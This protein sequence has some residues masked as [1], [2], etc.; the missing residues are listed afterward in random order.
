MKKIA[1]LASGGG[2]NFQAIIDGCTKG[3]IK[4]KVALLIYNRKNAY[5][6]KRAEQAGIKSVY[7]NRIAEGS[8]D[9]M[10]QKVYDELIS[11]NIDIIVLAGYLEKISLQVVK[12]WQNK[13]INTHPSLIPMFCGEGYYG[14]KVHK[15]VIDKGVKVSG[16]TIHLVDANYDTGPIIMQY[17]VQV[18]QDDTPKTLAQRILLHEHECLVSSVSLLCEDRILVQDSKANIIS[19]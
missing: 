8:T 17:P 13:I 11:A 4:G 15:A 10:N 18:K 19:K 12:K 3:L 16:C 7:V 5:A 2:T 6:K 1:V 14:Q 9:S